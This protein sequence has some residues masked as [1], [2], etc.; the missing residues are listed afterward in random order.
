MRVAV[1][2]IA[3]AKKPEVAEIAPGLL[4]V[5]VNAK[6]VNGAANVRLIEILAEHFQVPFSAIRIISGAT[7]KDKVIKVG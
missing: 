3:N 2:V 1:R 6:P 5:R 4:R 7:S